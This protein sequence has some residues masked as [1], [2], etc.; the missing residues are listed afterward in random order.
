MITEVEAISF[1]QSHQPMPGDDKLIEEANE[2][3]QIYDKIRKYFIQNP[4]EQCIP[5]FLNSFGGKNGLGVYQMV[6][7]VILMYDKE[8]VL[9]HILKAFESPYDSVK[10]WCIQ[11]A[12]NFPD[13]RLYEPLVHMLQMEDADIKLAAIDA[14][15]QLAFNNIK[16]KEVMDTIEAQTHQTFDEDIREFAQEV[17]ADIQA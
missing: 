16:V 4:N 6:E 5:L 9:P 12:A 14:L 3:L 8:I 15:A 11:I 17:L 1:L 10:Y 7:A 13:S 2:E